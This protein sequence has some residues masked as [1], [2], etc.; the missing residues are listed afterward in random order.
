MVYDVLIIGAG[1]I[2]S[3]IA[4]G[5]SRY[6]L[7]VALVEKENDVSCG[8]SKANSGIVH[9]GYNATPGTLKARFNKAGSQMFSALNGDLHF[10][11]RQCGSLVVAFDQED[12]DTLHKLVEKGTQNGVTD[13]ELLS[14]DQVRS[15]EPNLSDQVVGGLLCQTAGVTSPYEFTIALA[16]NAIANGVD[17]FINAEVESMGLNNQGGFDIKTS[18]GQLHSR[19]VINAAGA[20]SDQIA[21]MVGANNFKIC[22]RKGQYL[23]YDKSQGARVSRVV[24]QTP[25]DKG[26]GVLVTQTYHGNLMLGPDATEVNERY[27]TSTDEESLRYILSMAKKT[28][29][30]VNNAFVLTSFSGV[31]ATSD[32]K[33]FIVEESPIKGFF[34]VAGIDS[35]G[36]TSSPAIAEYVVTLLRDS[37]LPLQEKPDWKP[38][39]RAIILP[40]NDTFAGSTQAEDPT[41]HVICRCEQVTEAEI[42]DALHRGIP[43]SSTDS[44]KRR[45]RAGMGRCQGSY[46]RPKVREIIARETGLQDA[47]ITVRTEKSSLMAERLKRQVLTQLDKEPSQ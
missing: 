10:G 13:L 15:L 18:L 22:P 46:C 21:A 29:P 4:R 41:D 45:T 36:L 12:V 14:G 3:A 30:E 31:R 17:L 39:R 16:E 43:L 2:G 38:S 34:N 11:Y 9:G 44:I 33:D 24:F 35:P 42:V 6:E 26:K 19:L 27:D 28:L 1:V 23:L 7:S 5:L 25:T 37:G 32:R 20:Y 40:K 8:A 47:E